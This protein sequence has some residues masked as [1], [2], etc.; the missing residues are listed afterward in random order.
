MPREIK[1]VGACVRARLQNL[2][3]ETGQSFELILTR[4]ASDRLLYR[5][6]TSAF[7]D[8]FVLRGAMLLTIWFA[9]PHR[10]T[11][12]LDLSGFGGPSPDA[13]AAAL[14]EILA[15][16]LENVALRSSSLADVVLGVAGFITPHAI[17][18]ETIGRS[19]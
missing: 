17:A 4:Y 19:D 6:S 11:R 2:S 7:V 8:R 5:P 16:D 12:G 9:D 15:I 1:N 14:K 10:A 3:R 13:M 18:A